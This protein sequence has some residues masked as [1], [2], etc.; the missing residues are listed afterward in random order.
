MTGSRS[1]AACMVAAIICLLSGSA[2]AQDASAPDATPPP[3]FAMPALALRPPT[4][5]TALASGQDE[6]FRQL[7]AS[8]RAWQLAAA[9]A[10]RESIPPAQT[11]AA[12]RPALAYVGALPVPKVALTSGFGLRVHPLS[13][14][15]RNHDGIDIA[16]AFGT[17]VRATSD[18]VVEKAAWFG[19]YGLF[20]AL[21]NGPAMETRYGHLSRLLVSA[22]QN[23]RAGDIIGLVG[24]TGRS[25]GPHLHY[26]VR[27]SGRPVN[28]LPFLG[29]KSVMLQE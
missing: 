7:A 23:V 13:G 20:V 3:G 14:E 6:Q 10:L 28:P 21:R 16:A 22:G 29:R 11:K 25:T 19:G 18:G 2:A 8:G 9:Q 1:L 5:I 4:V 27:V 15:L 24:S 12:I 26:E 17:P